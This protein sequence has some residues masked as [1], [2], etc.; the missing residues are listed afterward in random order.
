[1]REGLCASQQSCWSPTRSSVRLRHPSSQCRNV[2]PR[3]CRYGLGV[4]FDC[5]RDGVWRHRIRKEVPPLF[6][7]YDP[8]TPR[9]WRFGRDIYRAASRRCALAGC[10]RQ[11]RRPSPLTWPTPLR[12][13]G[14]F[15]PDHCGLQK[16]PRTHRAAANDGAAAPSCEARRS[17]PAPAPS[18]AADRDKFENLL[19]QLTGFS[20]RA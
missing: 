3:E 8:D 12:F 15:S 2:A 10:G 7:R 11:H 17:Q 18:A 16:S 4:P 20:V 6:D 9:V 19:A 13:R 5:A 1:M 14:P